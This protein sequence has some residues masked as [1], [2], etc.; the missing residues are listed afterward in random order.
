MNDNYIY[1]VAPEDFP[2]LNYYISSK[3]FLPDKEFKAL[4]AILSETYKEDCNSPIAVIVKRACYAFNER[5]EGF[6]LKPYILLINDTI[7]F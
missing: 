6:N 3:N 1:T 7:L 5:F 2:H 4:K